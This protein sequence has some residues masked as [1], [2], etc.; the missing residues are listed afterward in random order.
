MN[1]IQDQFE[2]LYNKAKQYTESSIELYKLQAIGKTADVVSSLVSRLALFTIV[3]LFTLFVN[4]AISLFIGKQMGAYYLGFLI[5]SCFY[6]I[7]AV[8]VYFFNKTLIKTPITNLVIEK[9]LNP[10]KIEFVESNS[11]ENE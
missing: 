4:I 9:L 7:L 2:T 11:D 10:R 8:L 6:L 3:S 1:T 5:V